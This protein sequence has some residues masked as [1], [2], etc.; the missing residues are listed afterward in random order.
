MVFKFNIA[1]NILH[2]IQHLTVIA[3]HTLAKWL[4]RE[5]GTL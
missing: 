1:S 3:F 5:L 2:S 4:M